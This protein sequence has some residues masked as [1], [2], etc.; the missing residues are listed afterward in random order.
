M[1]DGGRRW[2]AGVGVAGGAA[3]VAALMGTSVARADT[4]DLFLSQAQDDMAQVSTLFSGL[5]SSSLPSAAG[6]L[7][8][9]EGQE[10]LIAQIQTQQDTFSEALQ[11][12]SQL[13]NADQQLSS[14]SGELVAA[15]QQFVNAVNTGDL[16][17][18][19]T[20]SLSDKLTGL[21]AGFGFLNAE[22]FQVLPAE[23]NAGL[24]TIFD[25]G[26]IDF[27]VID[28]GIAASAAA[29][30]ATDPA[31]LLSEATADLTEANSVLGGIDVSGQPSDL[32]SLVSTSTEIVGS[33]E[34]IQAVILNLQNVVVDAQAQGTSLP[35]YELVTEATNALF[36]NADQTLLN[37]DAALLASDQ[38][39]AN[40]ISGGTGLTDLQAFESV[41]SILGSLGADFGAFGT[42]FDAAFTPILGRF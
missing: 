40:A 29:P 27:N 24:S 14:A 7:S 5:D 33:Q 2:V 4:I 22:I 23:L 21:E 31:T 20:E 38:V 15:S 17:L 41:A 28:P 13:V 18:S 19:T 12:S 42:T 16:P 11:T 6:L 32:A 30:A 25:G 35:G 10:E 8:S 36:T 9:F 26:T 37:A 39:L 3:V 1:V 34:Q